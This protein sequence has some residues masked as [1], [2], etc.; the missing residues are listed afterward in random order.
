MSLKEI[1]KKQVVPQM[2]AKFRY[3]NNLA[4]PKVTKVT[5]NLGTGPALKDPKL[6][7]IMI[8]SIKKITGQIPIKR[9]AKK[10]I[11]GFGIKKGMIVGLQVT[12]R[13][14]R[15]YNFLDKL[16]NV[17]LPRI[18]DFKGLDPKKFDGHGN[19]TLG[20]KEHT[21]FPEIKTED[22]EKIHGLEIT[23]VTSA[24]C[25]EEAKE[26]FKLLGFPF[27]EEVKK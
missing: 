16:A 3:K 13:G 24:K 22:V 8:E 19:Y 9:Q 2:R 21:V 6:L 5:V 18:R 12:L 20:I 1:Y 26:L 27:K 11:S 14:E 7:D 4:V 15:M 25:N 10:A 17:V 23:I